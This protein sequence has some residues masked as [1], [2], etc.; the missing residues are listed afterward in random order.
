MQLNS[1]RRSTILFRKSPTNKKVTR[2]NDKQKKF[3]E[4]VSQ[5]KAFANAYLFSGPMGTGKVDCVVD[6]IS[7]ANNISNK[8]ILRNNQ[9][10]DVIF[11]EPEIEE[12]GEK[13]R[14]KDIGIS[15]VK[16]VMDKVQYYSYQ[17][18]FKFVVIHE[19]DKMTNAA[20]NSILKFVE[21]QQDC[22]ERHG[23]PSWFATCPSIGSGDF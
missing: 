5:K 7:K 10:P 16:E 22:Y 12:K 18:R 3:L 19:A 14:K 15:Q 2:I 23:V 9:H 11:I 13:V 6:F 17:S 21:R 20:A 4:K 1:K 8:D